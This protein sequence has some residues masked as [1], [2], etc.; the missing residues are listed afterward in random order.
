MC[1]DSK[2]SLNLSTGRPTENISKR[3]KEAVM[4]NIKKHSTDSMIDTIGKDLL[5]K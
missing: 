1:A 5:D 2:D 4:K 3:Q